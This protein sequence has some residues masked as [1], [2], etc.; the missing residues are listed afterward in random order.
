M[1]IS[2][3]REDNGR[4]VCRF[5]P[6]ST[7]PSERSNTTVL[8][9]SHVRSDSISGRPMLIAFRKKIRANDGAMT[10]TTPASRI[11]SAACSR[12]DPQPKFLPGDNHGPPEPRGQGGVEILEDVGCP[13][14]PV[15]GPQVPAGNN[16]IGVNVRRQADCS[17]RALHYAAS[18]DAIS[19]SRALA[20]A[21]ATEP[22]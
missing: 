10:A 15:P 6:A 5:P 4:I 19:P 20:A 18:G 21:V 8:P 22:R 3:I 7:Q 16:D 13:D 12:D 14:T 11:A 17:P 9:S 1:R 2:C